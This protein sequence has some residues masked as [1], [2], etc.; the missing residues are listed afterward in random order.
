MSNKMAMLMKAYGLQ[1][2][3]EVW[4]GERQG[5]R[6]GGRERCLSLNITMGI[7]LISFSLHI[8]SYRVFIKGS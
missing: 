5:R 7:I 3:S 2:K 8:G 6:E 1:Q 4:G